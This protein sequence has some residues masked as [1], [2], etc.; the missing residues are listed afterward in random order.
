[1][2]SEGS[3]IKGAARGAGVDVKTVRRLLRGATA[4]SRRASKLDPYRPLIKK[5]VCED[6]LTAVL[7][8]QDQ[9]VGTAAG[10]TVLKSSS[11]SG[12]SRYAGRTCASRR[13]GSG[14]ID[15]SP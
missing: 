14:Q 9:A 13:R 1:L 10:Y 15:L 12:R 2:L 5:L 4:R 6:E 8:L 3:S 7:V 11:R